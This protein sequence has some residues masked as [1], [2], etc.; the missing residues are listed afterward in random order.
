M[1]ELAGHIAVVTGS[2][3]G[4]G[5]A[6]AKRFAAEGAHVVLH[7]RDVAALERVH[8]QLEGTGEF[9]TVAADLRDVADVEAMREHVEDRL[10]IPDILVANAGG[11][12]ARPG[13][14][15][16]ISIEDWSATVDTNLTATFNTIKAFLPGMRRLGRGSIVTMSSAAARRPTI[17]SPVAYL[18][19]KAGIELLTQAVALQAGPDG[20]RANCLAPETIMTE[21]NEAMIPLEMRDEMIE[22]HPIRR[23]GTPDDIA[24]AA[25]FLTTEASSWISGIVVDVAGGSVLA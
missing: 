9:M 24:D 11:S 16:L 22:A 3:R 17:N 19:A 23:L 25:L 2:S 15:D 5:A 1:S 13:P 8:D 6:I 4:I 14:V 21:R 10:G 7:G 18:A 20:I 12:T